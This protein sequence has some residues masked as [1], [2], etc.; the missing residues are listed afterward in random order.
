MPGEILVACLGDSHTHGRVGAD[1][2]RRIRMRMGIEGWLF[3]NAGHNGDLAWNLG[4]RLEEVILC[5][6]DFALILIGSNDIM[7]ACDPDDAA[8][9]V[10]SNRLPRTPNIDWYESQ[11]R[12][13]VHRLKEATHAEIILC[14][15]PPL[16]EEPEGPAAGAVA[17]HNAIVGMLGRVE[18][19]AVLPLH[20]LLAAE[21]KK[22]PGPPYVPGNRKGPMYR[23]L[24]RRYLLGKTWDE[25]GRAQG[26][27]LLTDGIHLG[28]RAGGMLAALVE[29]HLRGRGGSKKKAVPPPPF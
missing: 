5:D 1:W 26:Y 12:D 8:A 9:Y 22:S 18:R 17:A 6:P 4:Q 16:G 25:V 11:L 24:L 21:I 14:T 29:D 3:I 2:V 15:L 27:S 23:A 10:E 20:R 19:L 7:G 28:D 13:I